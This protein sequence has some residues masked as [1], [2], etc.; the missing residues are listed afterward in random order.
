MQKVE[1]QLHNYYFATISHNHKVKDY[2]SIDEDAISMAAEK[3]YDY[4]D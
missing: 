3:E 2:I 4:G 1:V